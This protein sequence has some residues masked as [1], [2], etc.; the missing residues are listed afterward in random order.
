MKSMRRV[1]QNYMTVKT[2]ISKA[3][4][5]V[6]W[7]FMEK[8]MRNFGFSETW[9]LWVMALV[10]TVKYSVLIKRVQVYNKDQSSHTWSYDK[11]ILFH[12]IY[13]Y[14]VRIYSVTL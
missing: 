7:I 6:E 13:I 2:D 1:S 4:E 9:I 3:Y 8:T 12:F 11:K 10:S 5:G 14:C